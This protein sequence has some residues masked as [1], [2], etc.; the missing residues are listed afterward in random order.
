MTYTFLPGCSLD[1]AATTLAM[2]AEG[3]VR[4]LDGATKDYHRSTLA[5][6]AK[7]GPQ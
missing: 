4:W 2:A 1:G 7:G 3:G 5:L 6:P